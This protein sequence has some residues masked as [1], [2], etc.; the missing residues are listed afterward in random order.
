MG[1]KVQEGFAGGEGQEESRH[2]FWQ[3]PID[4]VAD[5][6]LNPTEGGPDTQFEDG[7][8]V[9]HGGSPN[10]G[11]DRPQIII[12]TTHSNDLDFGGAIAGDEPGVDAGE[13]GVRAIRNF[14][15]H[16]TD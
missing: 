9:D 1:E 3:A 5:R 8:D 14:S 10:P 15:K 4:G 16:K 11:D 12:A 2:I 13:E 7:L 6:G